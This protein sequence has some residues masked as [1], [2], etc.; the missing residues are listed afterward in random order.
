MKLTYVLGLKSSCD[1]DEQI[2]PGVEGTMASALQKAQY[3]FPRGC[4]LVESFP[5]IRLAAEQLY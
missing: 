2:Q 1:A 5:F 4:N 3:A